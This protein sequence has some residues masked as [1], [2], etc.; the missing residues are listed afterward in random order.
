MKLFIEEV[1]V[2]SLRTTVAQTQYQALLGKF[3][4]SEVTLPDIFSDEDCTF[5][6]GKLIS[7][8]SNPKFDQLLCRY[9][10]TKWSL[11]KDTMGVSDKVDCAMVICIEPSPHDGQIWVIA[12]YQE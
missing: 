10:E 9:L 12:E 6:N 3:E 11:P 8:Y 4:G 7:A 5:E 1:D 2:Q